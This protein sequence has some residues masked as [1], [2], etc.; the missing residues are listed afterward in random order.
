ML[1]CNFYYSLQNPFDSRSRTHEKVLKVFK[2]LKDTGFRLEASNVV[3]YGTAAY[4]SYLQSDCWV[5]KE[6]KTLNNYED[7]AFFWICGIK[8]DG[9]FMSDVTCDSVYVETWIRKPNA[10]F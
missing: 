2:K 7:H 6:S 4:K 5:L 10:D 1:L 9:I 3:G 8:T